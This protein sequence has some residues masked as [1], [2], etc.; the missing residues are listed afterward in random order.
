MT[1]SGAILSDCG[2][3]RYR[4]WRRV[5]ASDRICLFIMLN[6][7][8]A[9][10]EQDD[11]TIRRCMGFARSLGCGVLQVANL[12]AFRS[13]S[14]KELKNHVA[15]VGP[16]NDR[17]ISD[18]AIET[19]LSGGQIMCAWGTHGVHLNRDRMVV[20][21]LREHALLSLGETRDGHPRHPLYLRGDCKPLPFGGTT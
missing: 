10:A 7:S 2:T 21:L 4:L 17:H 11:P 1:A 13:P 20:A 16:S 12:F 6:P 18:A 19:D 8:T 14:P 5:T 3:Y 9:D 15:P